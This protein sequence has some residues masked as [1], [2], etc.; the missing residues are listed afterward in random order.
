MKSSHRFLRKN[1]SL[2]VGII[3]L[4]IMVGAIVFAPYLAPYDPYKVSIPERLEPM[5]RKHFLGTDPW[6]R[7]ILSRIIFGGRY[8][9]IIGIASISAS[10]IFGGFFGVLAGYYTDAKFTRVIVWIT[11]IAMAFPVII[12]GAMVGMIFGPGVL[13]TIIALAIAFFPRFIRLARG[14][15][16]SVKEEVYIV[17]ARSLG[18]SDLRLIV[19]HVIPNMISPII[20]MAVIWA[21]D[22]ISLEV[23]L[24]F[25]GLG[26]PPPAPSWG[27]ILQDNLRYFQM[28][29]MAVLWP[30]IAVAWAVQSLN[31]MGDRFR[32]ILDPK[33]R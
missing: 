15:T 18:M 5:S 25:L 6:G 8:S 21:S 11:D 19:I 1:I 20:V 17:A 32:D 13:N 4:F 26:V 24:S 10:M 33:M 16:L 3:M 28:E 14:T 23:A 9:L 27:T 31:L 30:C 22:A 7:D 2:V 29:P 12:L